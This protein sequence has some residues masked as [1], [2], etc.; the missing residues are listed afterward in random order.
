MPKL[1][2]R[3]LSEVIAERTLGLPE[4]KLAHEI[5]AYL[6]AEGHTAQLEPLMRDIMLWREHH[7]VVEATAVSAYP[8]T[9]AVEADIR[10]IL[11]EHFPQAKTII[12]DTRIDEDVVGG[13]RLETAREQLDLTVQATLNRFKRLT[14]EGAY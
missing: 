2:R 8:I 12:I 5:A 14:S 13:V 7:G 11:H 6:L 3:H 4:S 10:A 1:S 9:P